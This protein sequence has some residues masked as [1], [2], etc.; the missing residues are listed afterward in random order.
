MFNKTLIV[1]NNMFMYFKSIHNLIHF[2]LIKTTLE[3]EL[4]LHLTCIHCA[5]NNTPLIFSQVTLP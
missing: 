3:L 2:H 1:Q 4:F 5:H